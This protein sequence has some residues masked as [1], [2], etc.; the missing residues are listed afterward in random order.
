MKAGRT[1]KDSELAG[2]LPPGRKLEPAPMGFVNPGPTK[3][4]RGVEANTA[5]SKGSDETTS[6]FKGK[7]QG[8]HHTSTPVGGH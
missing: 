1:A 3:V 2:K 4:H 6:E 5:R 8:S 7:R